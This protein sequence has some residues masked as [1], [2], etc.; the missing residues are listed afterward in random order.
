M[1]RPLTAVLITLLC[2]VPVA[3]G[4]RQTVPRS[5]RNANYVLTAAL[6][7]AT[8][9]LE[10]SGR[11]EWRNTSARPAAELRFHL[12]WNAWRDAQ[13]TWM[14]ERAVSGGSPSASTRDA[15]RGAIDLRSLRLSGEAGVTDLLPGARFIAPD[16]GNASDRTVLAVPLPVA[17]APGGSVSLEFSWSARVPRTVDRTGVLGEYFF[18]AHWFPKIGVLQDEGWRAAQFHAHTEFFADFGTYD[19][20]LTVPDGWTVG[21]TGREVSRTAQGAGRTTHRYLED[22]VHDFAWTTSPHFIEQ[23]ARV[24]SPGRT[25][26]DVRLLL[27]PE[28]ASQADR[29]LTAVREAMKHWG[30]RLG[31]YPWPQLTVVDPVTVINPRVQ[32]GTTAGME[33]PTLITGETHWSTRWSEDLLEATIVH[34]V[35][36]QYFQSAVA[37]N[38]TD[39]AWLDEGLTTFVTGQIVE[40]AF[41]HRFVHVDRY[42]GGLIT[43]QHPAARWSRLHHAYGLDAY[44]MSPGWDA[45]IIPTWQQS[46]RTS[47]VTTYA[48]VPLALETLERLLGRDVMASVLST[49]YAQGRFA[50]P[51]PQDFFSIVESAAR[52]DMTWF[53]DAALGRPDLFDYAVGDVDSAVSA[54]GSWRSTVVVR[55]LA[56]GV[57]PVDVRVTFADGE[58]VLERWDGERT[59]QPFTYEHAAPVSRVDID[60]DRVL[61]LDT[62]RTNNSW[63]ATPLGARAADKWTMRWLAWMQ[64]TLMTYAFFA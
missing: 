9:T 17:V 25:P 52:R 20:R 50:H 5:A 61:V 31:P 64:Q 56:D 41:P 34:E 16:D 63:T 57:F 8:R 15:D 32:G 55:R 33:Y 51:T 53:F 12:Y 48:R 39:H 14:R 13:S 23:H 44:R 26:V 59:W 21:A 60:P 2:F 18:L 42:L 4:A 46:P 22:D 47:A 45:A 49:F 54:P 6:D 10:G 3:L 27:Q 7:P 30:E 11:L 43:W 1:T 36:H 24:A 37:T 58:V 38:E 19:V 62:H 28:H 29:Y 40:T 35:G